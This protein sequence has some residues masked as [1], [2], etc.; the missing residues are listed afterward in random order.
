VIF[1]VASPE[2]VLRGVVLGDVEFDETTHLVFDQLG[3]PR[4][5]DEA[6]T[7][8]EVGTVILQAGARSVT[9]RVQP[10]TGE[11]SVE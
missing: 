3:T 7:L 10:L 9:I 6:N 1:G 2:P 8:G 4:A 5:G 11:I